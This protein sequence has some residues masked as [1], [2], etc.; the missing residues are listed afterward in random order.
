MKFLRRWYWLGAG[1]FKKYLIGIVAGTLIGVL[2]VLNASKLVTTLPIKQT[3]RIGRIGAITLQTIPLDIQQKISRGLTKFSENG[4]VNPDVAQNIS[5]SDDGL[6]YTIT[7]NPNTFWSNGDKVSAHDLELNVADVEI[8]IPN[9]ETIEFKLKEPYSPFPSILSQPLLKKSSIGRI[10][11]RTHIIGVNDFRM[12]N[13]KTHNQV[14]I[15]MTLDSPTEQKIYTFYPTEKEAVTA[16]KLGHIDSIE[17]LSSPTLTDWTIVN[18]RAIS[19]PNRYLAVFF[20]TADLNLQEKSIRQMLSYAIN[21]D[22]GENRVISPISKNSWAYNPQVK[23]YNFN[24]KTAQDMF[25]KQVEANPNFSLSIELT[26][27][28]AYTEAAQQIIDNWQQIGVDTTIKIVSF[29]DTNDYQ[30][31]LI[32]QQIPQD[33]DQYALWHSTQSSNITHYQNPKIDKLLED[34]RKEQNIEKRELIYQDFQRF[35]VEDSPTAFLYNL[36]TYTLSRR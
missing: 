17:Q 12:T 29:P 33:P 15:A 4:D 22:S 32:G 14:I 26:T 13:I 35:L 23:P 27:T 9:D 30:A 2:A 6:I 19:Q 25:D 28:P 34:G 24:L 1:F 7:I 36:K 20:N 5:V 18:T 8:N 3:E 31:L 16:F 21:K 10:F 11:K